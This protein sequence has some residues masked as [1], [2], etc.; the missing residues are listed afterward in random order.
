MTSEAVKPDLPTPEECSSLWSRLRGDG[1]VRKHVLG[2]EDTSWET[3]G[4]AALVVF[5]S[6]Q[7]RH[8]YSK[9]EFAFTTWAPALFSLRD[10]RFR[11][12]R[13]DIGTVQSS[14]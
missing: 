8:K 11:R 7:L 12:C 10:G 4:I 3:P 14:L 13:L 2:M 9:Q 1:L 5:P 6:L